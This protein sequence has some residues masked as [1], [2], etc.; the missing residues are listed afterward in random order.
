MTTKTSHQNQ[1]AHSSNK[2]LTAQTKT[3]TASPNRGG[4]SCLFLDLK[5]EGI[6]RPWQVK[7]F[8][9]D[10]IGTLSQVGTKK[11]SKEAGPF[12][13]FLSHV[14]TMY[15]SLALKVIKRGFSPAVGIGLARLGIFLKKLEK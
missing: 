13:N 3:L 12:K 7:I 5:K 2:M 4:L 9:P 11:I 1:I 14:G 6:T 10:Q 8:V 15:L